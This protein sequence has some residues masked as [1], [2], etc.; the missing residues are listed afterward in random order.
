MMLGSFGIMGLRDIHKMNAIK[1]TLA[2]IINCT[3]FV[4]F[5]LKGLVA[6]HL[7]LVV[8]VG[9]IVGGY[10]GARSAK[11]VNTRVLQLIVV[12]IGVVVSTWLFIKAFS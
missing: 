10:A 2:A 3:A 1:T 5:A 7:A 6:W 9:A 4:F 12:I 8:G 11:R